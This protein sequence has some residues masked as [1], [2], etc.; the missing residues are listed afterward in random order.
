MW[1]CVGTLAQ[2]DIAC[3]TS[4]VVRRP[5][6]A[7]TLTMTEISFTPFPALTSQ[8]L[9]LRRLDAQDQ[10]EIFF[11]RS[12]ARV[13][14]YLDREPARTI[15]DAQQFIEKINR[16]VD[17]NKALYWAICLKEN[18]R[19]IGTICCF[20]ISPTSESAEIGYELHPFYQGKGIMHEAIS[21]VLEYGFQVLQLK[22]IIA[23]PSCDNL[24][25]IRLLEKHGFI[26]D[27]DNS[28][29]PGDLLRYVLKN[30]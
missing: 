2:A 9:R 12:D 25:S 6:A 15:E 5:A 22:A 28:Q 23:C 27:D 19:L 3:I 30:G 10:Q 13:N 4:A 7:T 21:L 16:N 29:P 8:R 1:I 24:N 18:P 20:D 11:L 14:R 26:K 17:E